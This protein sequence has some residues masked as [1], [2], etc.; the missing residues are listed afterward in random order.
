MVDT[1]ADGW[2]HDSPRVLNR[3]VGPQDPAS[4]SPALEDLRGGAQ[5]RGGVGEE[6][7]EEAGEAGEGKQGLQPL[8]EQ[9]ALDQLRGG[10]H[11]RVGV[12]D[13]GWV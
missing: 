3:A 1:G 10:A 8:V 4:N 2:I 13:G 5:Q 12:Q 6:G 9:L 11:Q 7:G